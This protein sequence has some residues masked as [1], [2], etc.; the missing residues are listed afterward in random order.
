MRYALIT[1]AGSG[2]GFELVKDHIKN[3]WGV[4]ALSHHKSQ[5]L[6]G[7]KQV[8][9]AQ[10]KIILCDVGKTDSVE[11]A[12]EEVRKSVG[13]LDRIFN[14]AGIDRKSEWTT[15]DQT[16]IDFMAEEYNV[17]A[18]GA[19]RVIKACL[20]L[21]ESGTIIVN[22]SSEAGGIEEQKS[23]G[24]YGYCMSKAALNMGTKILDN[25]LGRKGVC[26][27]AFHPG[28]MRTGMAGPDSNMDPWEA[29]EKIM[30]F[31]ENIGG[32]TNKHL[33]WDYSGRQLKW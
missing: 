22:I 21:I 32:L 15:L 5:K 9:P 1:G 18:V 8:F 4:L 11:K 17:N 30:D 13:R 14:N 23:E 26:F 2:L 19:L 24:G 3:G 7:L 29:S 20:P 28:R 12:I 31:L 10:L 16:D 27:F 6:D 25:W 33:F